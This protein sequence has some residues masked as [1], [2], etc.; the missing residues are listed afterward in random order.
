MVLPKEGAENVVRKILASTILLVHGITAIC[1]VIG[2]S[3]G[4]WPSVV[5][6]LVVLVPLAVVAAWLARA[7]GLI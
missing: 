7:A 4:N 6:N 5:V 1:A 3:T 2:A